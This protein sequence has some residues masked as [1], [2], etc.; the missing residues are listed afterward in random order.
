M[1]RNNQKILSTTKLT[2][3]PLRGMYFA[4]ESSW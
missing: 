1:R 4:Q 3:F 2:E